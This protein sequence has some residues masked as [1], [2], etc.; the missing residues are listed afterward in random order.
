MQ[1]R[2]SIE[3]RYAEFYRLFSRD[4]RRDIAVYVDLALKHG[5]P[6]LEVGCRTGR[7]SARL[8]EAGLSVTGIDI[9]RP[10]LEL[11]V[12]AVR[13][14]TSRA[15]IAD[16]DLRHQPTPEAYGVGLVTLFSFNELIDVEEQRL[17]LRHLRGSIASPGL[18]AIDFFCPLSIARPELGDGWRTLEREVDGQRLLLQDRR[19]MLTPLLEKRVQSFQ[20]EGGASGE[21]TT[22]RRYIPPQY[23]SSLLSEA[24]LEDVK[25]VQGYDLTNARPVEDKDRPQGP[26]IMLGTC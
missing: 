8:A 16:F 18:V 3:R 9:C 2:N 6:V 10:M 15:R 23:A 4:F 5:G 19:E 7:V 26:F 22:H 11:A 20:I 21:Y 1:N 12:D 14:W 13:P 17:F 25:W 24:G